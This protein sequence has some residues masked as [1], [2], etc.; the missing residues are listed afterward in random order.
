LKKHETCIN[1]VVIILQDQHLKTTKH[2]IG[3]NTCSLL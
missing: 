3:V 1:A 2:H